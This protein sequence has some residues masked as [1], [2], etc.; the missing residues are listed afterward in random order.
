MQQTALGWLVYSLTK[1]SFYLG[2]LAMAL[3]LPVLFF[4]LIGGLIADR[5]RKRNILIATQG[6]SII[7]AILLSVIAYRG[8]ANIWVILAVSAILG[9]INSIDIP[10]RQSYIIEIAG[11]ENLLNAVALNSTTFH[12]ARIIGP[13]ISGIVI[14]HIGIAPCFYINVFSFLPVIVALLS[15]PL[16]Q[17]SSICKSSGIVRDFGDGLTFIKDN[18]RLL[19]LILTITVFSLF[20]IPFSQFL[21]VFADKVF[22][23]GVRGFG[24][25][26]SSVG[27]GSALAGFII[28]FRGDIQKKRLF[29]S[30][31]S[32]IS[33]ISLLAFAL[34]S[35]FVL[36]LVFLCV[37]GF[38]MVSFLAT[39]NSYIQLKTKDELRGRVMSVYTMMFL[40]MAPVGAAFM[41][42]LAVSLGIQKTIVIN[43]IA[44][45]AGVIFFRNKW[46]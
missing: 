1:S 23:V 2:L 16:K 3:S 19:Y 5:F 15:I 33:P 14:D 12:T 39:A 9:I 6:L 10:V 42:T 7:P 31:T 25:M 44:C 37:V 21:P 28:A 43:T 35:N 22:K 27:I 4:T 45:L 13:F 38:N 11:R 17:D 24:Y 40:G 8:G 36:S 46:K 20:V 18:S 34:S 29:M 30:I 41:G 26:M 32:V